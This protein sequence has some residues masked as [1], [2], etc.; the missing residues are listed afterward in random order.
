MEI[1]FLGFGE[2]ASTISKGLINHGIDVCTSVEGRSPLTI[3]LAKKTG[4][5]LY[6]TNKN[7]AESADILFSA[8]TPSS[9]I[10]IAQEV[11]K[12]VKG[13]YVDINNISPNTA[14]KTLSFIENGKTVDA[15]IIGPITTGLDTQIIVSGPYAYQLNKMNKY[16][17]NIKIIGTDIGQASA[18]KILRSSFTKG[19]SA[20]LFETIYC[21]YKMDIH[22]DVINYISQTEGEGFKD[23]ATSRMV[24]TIV[25]AKRRYEEMDEV[26]DLLSEC[27]DPKMSKAT[28]DIFEKIQKIG[29]LKKKP[30]NYIQIFELIETMEL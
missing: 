24:S 1:G 11:G 25:H 3:E 16:G 29:K 5:N 28:R 4:V 30:E 6:P 19:V 13:V 7:I 14:K 9:A 8:V 15:S 27:E 20:L 21:A 12:Y 10:Q 17:M 18:V 26:I 22:K 23:S 2:V